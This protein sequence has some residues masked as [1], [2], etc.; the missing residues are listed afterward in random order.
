VLGGALRFG[1]WSW[2]EKMQV[3]DG[4]LDVSGLTFTLE[5]VVAGSGTGIASGYNWL[6]YLATRDPRSL[7]S[8]VLASSCTS[9]GNFTLA[10]PVSSDLTGAMPGVLWLDSEA[11]LASAINAGSVVVIVDL[12]NMLFVLPAVLSGRR[13]GRARLRDES[14]SIRCG[15]H[16]LHCH[17][18][19][20][21]MC[22][23]KCRQIRQFDNSRLSGTGTHCLASCK[24][25]IFCTDE[26]A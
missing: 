13:S 17:Q 8:S 18:S 11:V 1:G 23:T 26:T 5:D 25:Y 15:L 16:Q 7:G 21:R 14:E 10:T 19:C 12:Q 24:A 4:N 20:P 6:T 9:S 2:T 22:N 3:I